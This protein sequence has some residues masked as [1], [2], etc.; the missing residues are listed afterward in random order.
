M[1]MY[2]VLRITILTILEESVLA[3]VYVIQPWTIQPN[4][5]GN[6]I[7]AWYVMVFCAG[8][9]TVLLAC[10]TYCPKLL[11]LDSVLQALSLNWSL[12]IVPSGNHILIATSW[13]DWLVNWTQIVLD[14][15]ESVVKF[16]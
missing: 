6:W 8:T 1:S 16:R 2:L 10:L 13:L 11:I 4:H 5:A 15:A 9:I 7:D 3:I 14:L 12:V